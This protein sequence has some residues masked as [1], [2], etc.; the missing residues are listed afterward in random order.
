MHDSDKKK[1]NKKVLIEW[2][3]G[4]QNVCVGGLKGNSKY[5]QTNKERK[6]IRRREQMGFEVVN[7]IFQAGECRGLP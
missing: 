4:H 1:K 3:E 6:I 5:Y 7:K 2:K